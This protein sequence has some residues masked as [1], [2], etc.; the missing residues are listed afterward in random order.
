MPR[1]QYNTDANNLHEAVLYAVM[2]SERKDV[3]TRIFYTGWIISGVII[4]Y[5]A[6]KYGN[7]A[8]LLA[9][10]VVGIAGLILWLSNSWW[11]RRLYARYSSDYKAQRQFYTEKTQ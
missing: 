3:V 7:Q 2:D 10:F 11:K 5:L 6:L 1:E 9:L 8:A 4:I